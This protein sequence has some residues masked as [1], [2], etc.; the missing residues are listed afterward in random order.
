MIR[1]LI[2]RLALLGARPGERATRPVIR[3]ITL[4]P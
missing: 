1:R 2:A 3:P 4:V